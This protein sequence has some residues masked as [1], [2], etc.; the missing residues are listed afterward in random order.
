MSS[1]NNFNE[2]PNHFMVLDAISRGMK[3]IEDIAKVTKLSKDEVELIINDLQTQKLVIKQTKKGFFGNKKIEVYVA[4][5]GFKILESKK[6][7][8]VNKSKYL[9]QLYETGNRGQMQSYMNDNRMWM[10]MM[11]FSGLINAVMFTSMMSF[12][13]MSMNPAENVQSEAQASESGG[14]GAEDSGAASDTGDTGDYSDMDVGG[15]DTG[16]FDSF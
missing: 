8:L 12:M 1:N 10:P 2:S 4:D 13:G 16:G 6:Q 9:Q 3:K 7:E 15:M 5:T 14:S 11:L